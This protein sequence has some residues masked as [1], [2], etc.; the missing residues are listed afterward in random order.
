MTSNA[1][2]VGLQAAD[3]ES[4]DVFL[5]LVELIGGLAIFLLGMDRMTEA[6]RLVAGGRLREILLRMRSGRVAGLVTG[7][8]ITA[9]VQSSSVTT[10]LL[11]GFVTSNSSEWQLACANCSTPR[12]LR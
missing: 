9:L 6:L 4:V 7:A 12:F 10:V 11:V 2:F 1:L 5:L 3:A 8:G